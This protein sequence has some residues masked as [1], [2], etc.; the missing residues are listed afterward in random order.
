MSEYMSAQEQLQHYQFAASKSY[1]SFMD[2]L[3]AV[4]PLGDTVQTVQERHAEARD[5]TNYKIFRQGGERKSLKE[6]TE[7]LQAKKRI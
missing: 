4:T 5:F 7:F 3:A 2:F 1:K 6:D